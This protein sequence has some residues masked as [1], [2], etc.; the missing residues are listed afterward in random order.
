MQH[1]IR[2]NENTATFCDIPA[3]STGPD[4]NHETADKPKLRDILQKNWP[5]IFKVVK[6]MKVR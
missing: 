5:V 3:K 4:S 6:V 2:Y 1:L